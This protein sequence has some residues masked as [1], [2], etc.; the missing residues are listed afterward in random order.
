MTITYGF[1]NSVSG[2]RKYD[3][4]QISSIFDGII[5]DGVFMAIGDNLV[6]TAATGMN[7]NVGSG[8]AWFNHT[9][10]NNDAPILISVPES[11]L[12]LNRIDSV[13]L[14][15][16]NTNEVRAN[17]IKILKGTPGSSPV[18]PVPIVSELVSQYKLCDIYVGAGVSEII[19][20][21]ITNNI[22][23][24]ECP[25]ITGILETV[26]VDSLLAQWGDQFNVWF[27]ELGNILDENTAA[28]LLNL[29][30]EH[31]TDNAA[32]SDIRE[33]IN[34]LDAEVAAHTD[35][36]ANPHAVT[37]AQVSLGNVDNA[38]QMPIA[39]GTFTGVATAQNNTA[40]TTK[41]VRNITLSTADPSGGGNGD[42]WIKYA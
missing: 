8:R 5:N 33:Q 35:D 31:Y 17:S 30:N 32:H 2:D 19:Q 23:T 40:Y 4:K 41:Q 42:V 20:A 15:I 24:S 28:N 36:N 13:V 6:V 38:K 12:I 11:D 14:E 34:N 22:G 21:N 26:N 9:W 37:K 10:T 25:F 18:A 16:N 29:I 39:G 3:A 27:A 7:I 1:Y